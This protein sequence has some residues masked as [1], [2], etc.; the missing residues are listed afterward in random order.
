MDVDG[1][2]MTETDIVFIALV[3]RNYHDLYDFVKS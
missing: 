2:I 3:Y 1:S